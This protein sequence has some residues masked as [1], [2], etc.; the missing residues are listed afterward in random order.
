MLG[1]VARAKRAV[2]RVGWFGTVLVWYVPRFLVWDA[3]KHVVVKPLGKGCKYC[4]ENKHKFGGWCKRQAVEFPGRAKK[5]GKAAWESAKKAPK[6]V[7]RAVKATPG[8][9]KKLLKRLW[10]IM[11]KIPAAMKKLC[12][13]LWE[14]LKRVGKAVGDVFLRVVAVLHTAV[15]AVLDFFKNIK[16]K[17]VWNGVCDIAQ[18]IFRGLPRAMWK[19]VS[20]LGIVVAGIIIGIFGLTGKLIVFLFEALWYVANCPLPEVL[21][22]RR[23]RRSSKWKEASERTVCDEY[24]PE[25]PERWSV[26]DDAMRTR[27][28]RSETSPGREYLH[29]GS[30]L[31]AHPDPIPPNG[32]KATLSPS[33][34]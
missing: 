15:A 29:P 19:V 7:W 14:S 26:G 16:L 22:K 17:D 8:V 5:A 34:M 23:P 31:E 27:T 25:Y 9:V 13:W 28:W 3:P 32:S 18:A 6:D 20:S 24:E 10:E 12:V 2:V 4:W 1:A 11:T 21:R 30:F 33:R